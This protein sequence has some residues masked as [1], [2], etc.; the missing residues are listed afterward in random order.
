MPVAAVPKYLGHD[1]TEASPALRF[2]MYLNLWGIN[3]RTRQLLWTTHDLDYEVRGQ[4]R[5]EREIKIE[6]KTAALKESG[7]LRTRDKALMQAL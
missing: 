5:R 2:G 6:N 7:A 4:E 1:F 3:R